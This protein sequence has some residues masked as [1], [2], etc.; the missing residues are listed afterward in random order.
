[1]A[2][3]IDLT[4]HLLPGSLRSIGQ[5]TLGLDPHE[6]VTAG[7]RYRTIANQTGGTAYKIQHIN[8]RSAFCVVVNGA[9]YL[10]VHWQYPSYRRLFKTFFGYL[11]QKHDVDHVMARNLARS[12][13]VP[14]LL[15]A[16][17]PQTANRSHGSVE[18]QGLAPSNS[19]YL[20]KTYPLDER[21]FHKV[22][23]R[24]VY[25][26]QRKEDLGKGYVKGI[27]SSHG[28]TLKQRGIWNLAFSTF[29]PF[30]TPPNIA[31]LT[32]I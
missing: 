1:M 25:Q 17:V 10:Y 16:A 18:R 7:H 15:L 27:A 13:S 3:K 11:P 19:V 31:K 22:M 12:L 8:S 5:L 28:L 29:L 2:T 23:G 32:R 14:F 21:M 6:I 24:R 4:K 30:G 26:R 9:Y 20:G